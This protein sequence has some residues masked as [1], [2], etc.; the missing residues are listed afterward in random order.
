LETALNPIPKRGEVFWVAFDPSVGGE[1]QKIRPA[2][3][4]SNDDANRRLNRVLVVP[5]TSNTARL[6]AGEAFVNVNGAVSKAIASQ[7]TTVSKLRFGDFFGRLSDE[8]L[9]KVELIV[10]EQLGL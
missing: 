5:L 2:I 3:V 4:L 1:I 9:E 8:D 10:I 6:Y 7:L